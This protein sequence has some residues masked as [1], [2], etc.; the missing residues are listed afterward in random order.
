[1]TAINK[2]C[3][4]LQEEIRIIL[5]TYLRVYE[6]KGTNYMYLG[7]GTLVIFIKT[8]FETCGC[9]HSLQC[10]KY[11]NLKYKVGTHSPTEAQQHKE[12][13]YEKLSPYW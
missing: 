1:M 6:L 5:H 7:R 3:I 12:P 8:E 11:W 9:K 13:S 2:N 10:A 4:F